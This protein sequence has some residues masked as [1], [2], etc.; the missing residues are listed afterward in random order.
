MMVHAVVGLAPLAAASFVLEALSM[1]VLG[2]ETDVWALLLRGSLIAM[3]AI[4]IPSIW[5][6]ISERNHMY[7]NWPSSHRV[8]LLLSVVLVTL[9][10]LELGALAGASEPLRFRSLLGLAVVVGNCIAVFSLSAFGLRITLG[11][12]SL[13]RTSYVPDMDFDPPMNILECVADF[14]ADPPKLIDVEKER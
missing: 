10:C 6:G 8:K 2:I 12:Q 3:L 4:S 1:T 7:V 5:T 11:R 14:A 9:L 13:A